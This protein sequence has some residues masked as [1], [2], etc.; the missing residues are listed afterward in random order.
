MGSPDLTRILSGCCQDSPATT[1]CKSARQSWR[2]PALSSPH[3]WCSPSCPVRPDNR[4]GGLT[5]PPASTPS[6]PPS[7]T[8]TTTSTSTSR[9]ELAWTWVSSPTPYCRETGG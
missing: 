8:N 2:A 5:C 3:Y 7:T 1:Q 9:R 6:V 4:Q